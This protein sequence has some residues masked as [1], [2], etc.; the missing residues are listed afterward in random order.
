MACRNGLTKPGLKSN[1]I[2]R[3]RAHIAEIMGGENWLE[4]LKFFVCALGF[5]YRLAFHFVQSKFR[6]SSFIFWKR[7]LPQ[8]SA[9]KVWIV[10]R[11]GS[12]VQKIME[13]TEIQCFHNFVFIFKFVI[14]IFEVCV[15][16]MQMRIYDMLIRFYFTRIK[17][18]KK[19]CWKLCKTW[20]YCAIY[21]SINSS[22]VST[23]RRAETMVDGLPRAY[24]LLVEPQLAE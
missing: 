3:Q 12:W 22:T 2:L 5:I 24:N 7:E 11:F 15:K 19:C 17:R 1:N 13:F 18:A 21:E 8:N 23:S 14:V 6:Y 9:S 10:S 20:K 4:K 16:M